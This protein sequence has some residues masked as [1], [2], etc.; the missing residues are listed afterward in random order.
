MLH[1]AIL[2]PHFDLSLGQVQASG[3]LDPSGTAQVFV[4]VE[5]LLQLQKLGVGVSGAQP[6]GQ[7]I[8]CKLKWGK[9]LATH[10]DMR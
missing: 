5:F 10:K 4:K 8:F 3:N 6:A 1:P 2:E 9:R 7:S